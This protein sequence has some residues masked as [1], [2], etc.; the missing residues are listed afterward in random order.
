MGSSNCGSRNCAIIMFWWCI[1]PPSVLQMLYNDEQEEFFEP[2]SDSE[3]S[4]DGAS[5]S[6]STGDENQFGVPTP[7]ANNIIIPKRG[8]LI[9]IDGMTRSA[10]RTQAEEFFVTLDAPSFG[11]INRYDDMDISRVQMSRTPGRRLRVIRAKYMTYN[12]DVN[13]AQRNCV[14]PMI[15][16]AVW[17]YCFMVYDDDTWDRFVDLEID[18]ASQVCME[19]VDRHNYLTGSNYEP[20]NMMEMVD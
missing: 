14:L 2:E 6:E 11:N 16:G 10:T 20:F 7:M 12:A 8:I 1:L 5:E 9:F 17:L 19:Y 3:T 4:E 18:L 13:R 15:F